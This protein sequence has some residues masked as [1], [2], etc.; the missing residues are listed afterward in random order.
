[1]R[2]SGTG[3]ASVSILSGSTPR[4]PASYGAAAGTQSRPELADIGRLARRFLART[5]AAARAE[6]ESVG[7]LLAEA[8]PAGPGSVT[9]S[10]VQCG[11]YIITEARPGCP[12]PP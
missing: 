4:G 3:R 10:C 7:R 2:S 12:H 8:L 1:V 6:E 11:L 9:R 5:V